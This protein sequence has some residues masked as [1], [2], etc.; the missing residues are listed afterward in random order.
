MIA[1]RL[2]QI[3]TELGELLLVLP[4]RLEQLCLVLML[5][6]LGRRRTL[7]DEREQLSL[8]PID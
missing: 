8:E 6:R 1:L 2:Q 4:L 3:L 5:G 7:L